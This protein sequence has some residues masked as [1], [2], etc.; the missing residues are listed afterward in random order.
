M[1]GGS[2]GEGGCAGELCWVLCWQGGAHPEQKYLGGE[3]LGSEAR[4]GGDA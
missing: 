2:G 3:L 4:R 1:G